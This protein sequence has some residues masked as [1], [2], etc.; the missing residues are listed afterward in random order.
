MHYQAYQETQ[1]FILENTTFGTYYVGRMNRDL[2]PDKR[3]MYCGWR[4]QTRA[5][6]EDQLTERLERKYQYHPEYRSPHLYFTALGN[7]IAPYGIETWITQLEAKIQS[8]PR[9]FSALKKLLTAGWLDEDY[10][11][12]SPSTL[13]H[14]RIDKRFKMKKSDVN[15]LITHLRRNWGTKG[16]SFFG[17][18]IVSPF[19]DLLKK[20]L[21]ERTESEKASDTYARQKETDPDCL[22]KRARYKCIHDMIRKGKPPKQ[23]TIEK[24]G[25]TDEEIEEYT[26]INPCPMK[27]DLS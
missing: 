24:Y 14:F 18:K 7:S 13:Y 2:A 22:S 4:N 25:F 21:N 17:K 8:N 23:T 5:A 1:I 11:V 6:T 10:G 26:K 15:A 9:R 3:E 19:A 12:L 16:S 27:F 20:C